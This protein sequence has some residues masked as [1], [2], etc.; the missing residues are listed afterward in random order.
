MGLVEAKDYLAEAAILEEIWILGEPGP[1]TQ[2]CKRLIYQENAIAFVLW[3]PRNTARYAKS[4]AQSRVRLK[5]VRRLIFIPNNLEVLLLYLLC[6][7]DAYNATYIF[8]FISNKF[9]NG[10]GGEGGFHLTAL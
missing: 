3:L 2:V 6:T 1:V 9:W 5:M 4:F 8:R 10:G 7:G